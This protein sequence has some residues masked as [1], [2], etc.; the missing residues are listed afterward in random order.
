LVLYK[1]AAELARRPEGHE[2]AQPRRRA[3]FI[4]NV[5]AWPDVPLAISQGTFDGLISTNE[6]VNSAKLF[7]SGLRHSLQ[8]HQGMGLYVPMVNKDFWGKLEKP[9]QEKILQ[10]WAEN[11]PIYRTNT[12]KSQEEGRNALKGHE[13]AFVDVP[14]DELAAVR[15]KMLPEQDKAAADAHMSAELVK[16]VMSDVGA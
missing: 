10:L 13:V 4:P 7:D 5:T 1:E 15:K 9:M 12:A 6:S 8:D 2:T 3:E 14:Q 11:L 16:L